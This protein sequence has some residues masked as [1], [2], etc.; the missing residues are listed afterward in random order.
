MFRFRMICSD[1][2]D[3]GFLE[4]DAEWEDACCEDPYDDEDEDNEQE[5]CD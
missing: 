2:V 4:E 5:W 1:D 3:G